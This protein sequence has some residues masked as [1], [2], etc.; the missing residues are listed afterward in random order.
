MLMDCFSNHN[1][2][3]SHSSDDHGQPH[4][5]YQIKEEVEEVYN[6][7]YSAKQSNGFVNFNKRLTSKLKKNPLKSL[8]KGN[9]INDY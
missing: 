5:I 4:N 9:Q 2:D 1:H 7:G 3:H 6:I 8:F